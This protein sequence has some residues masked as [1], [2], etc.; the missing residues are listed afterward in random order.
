[1]NGLKGF[2]HYCTSWYLPILEARIRVSS[3]RQL[4]YRS[5]SPVLCNFKPACLRMYSCSWNFTYNAL[6]FNLVSTETVI[7]YSTWDVG[8]DTL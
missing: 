5:F 6:N 3:F 8:L 2:I 1:M 4:Q 7:M